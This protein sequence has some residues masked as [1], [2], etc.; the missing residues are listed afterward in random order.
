MTAIYQ[1]KAERLF[2]EIDT[3][4]EYRDDTSAFTTGAQ[5]ERSAVDAGFRQAPGDAMKNY[6]KSPQPDRLCSW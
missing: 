5:H 1:G 6:E 3:L 4:M 2:F